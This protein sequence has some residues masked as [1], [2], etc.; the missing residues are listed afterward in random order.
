MKE[1][2]ILTDDFFNEVQQY[3]NK[4]NIKILEQKVVRKNKDMEMLVEIPSSVGS[5]KYFCKAKNKKKVNDGDLSSIY[6]QAQSKKLPVLF[7]TTGELTK[8]AKEM[9]EKEFKGLKIKKL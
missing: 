9:L 5:L 7:I 8:K 4:N 6:I 2:K 1:Q 3:F